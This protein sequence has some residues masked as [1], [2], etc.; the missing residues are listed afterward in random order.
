[1]IKRGQM[2]E[3]MVGRL[4]NRSALE[5]GSPF[6]QREYEKGGKKEE[7]TTLGSAKHSARHFT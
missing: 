3:G 7:G 5:M 1:M 2:C 4:G 6:C